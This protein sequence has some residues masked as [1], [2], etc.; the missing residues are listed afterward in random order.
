MKQNSWGSSIVRHPRSTSG[1]FVLAPF[2]LGPDRPTTPFFKALTHGRTNAQMDR[3][4]FFSTP[5]V[6][7]QLRN[8]SAVEEFM[9]GQPLQSMNGLDE[10][11]VGE[12]GTSNRSRSLSWTRHSARRP[13]PPLLFCGSQGAHLLSARGRTPKP[14]AKGGCQ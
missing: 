4:S 8:P 10:H 2:Q 5:S 9:T 13:S 12:P 11:D 7:K 6:M 14:P 1:L 3:P